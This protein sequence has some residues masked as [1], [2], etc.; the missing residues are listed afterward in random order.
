[1]FGQVIKKIAENFYINYLLN[2]NKQPERLAF[3]FNYFDSNFQYLKLEIF[4]AE[5][6]E[7]VDLWHIPSRKTF[8]WRKCVIDFAIGQLP[9]K[10]NSNIVLRLIRPPVKN[11]EII[12]FSSINIYTGYICNPTCSFIECFEI[13]LNL[14]L[15]LNRPE[16]LFENAAAAE[17]DKFSG[18][19]IGWTNPFKFNSRIVAGILP[20]AQSAYFNFI[21]LPSKIIEKFPGVELNPINIPADF[22]K[23]IKFG[24]AE[25]KKIKLENTDLKKEE[26]TVKPVTKKIIEKVIAGEPKKN[27]I[28]NL[29]TEEKT[30][31]HIIPVKKDEK[32]NEKKI[33]KKE[34]VNIAEGKISELTKINTEPIAEDV[35]EKETK[36]KEVKPEVPEKISE[37]NIAH[38]IEN[39][40][41]KKSVLDFSGIFD[42]N[43]FSADIKQMSNEFVAEIASEAEQILKNQFTALYKTFQFNEKINWHANLSTTEYN[44]VSWPDGNYSELTAKLAA[45]SG[46]IAPAEK[47][48][49]SL[50]AGGDF[51]PNFVFGQNREFV[52]LALAWR[53]TGDARFISKLLELFISF[54][55]QNKTGRGINFASLFAVSARIVNWMAVLSLVSADREWR[56]KFINAGIIIEIE[57]NL[58]FALKMA[59][60]SNDKNHLDKLIALLGISAAGF[61]GCEH[62]FIKNINQAFLEKLKSEFEGQIGPEGCHLSGSFYASYSVGQALLL[63]FDGILKNKKALGQFIS[64]LLID[65]FEEFLRSGLSAV[66]NFLKAAACADGEVPCIGEYYMKFPFPFTLEQNFD[67]V[68][69]FQLASHLLNDGELK[70][71]TGGRKLVWPRLIFGRD[72]LMDYESAAKSKPGAAVSSFLKSGYFSVKSELSPYGLNNSSTHLI[73]DAGSEAESQYAA[74]NSESK[75]VVMP[76]NDVL[77]FTLNHGGTNFICDSGPGIFIENPAMKEYQRSIFSHNSVIL[78]RNSVAK[79]GV[80]NEI[81]NGA[82]ANN[83]STVMP[84]VKEVKY[85]IN[86][87]F[88]YFSAINDM[89]VNYGIEGMV[90]RTLVYSRPYYVLLLDDILSARKKPSYFDIEILFH[91][92]QDVIWQKQEI[93]F[94]KNA[95]ILKSRKSEAKVIMLSSA[96]QKVSVSTARGAQNPMA[97]WRCGN[98]GEI[99]ETTTISS[100]MGFAKAP[101]RIYTLLYLINSDDQVSKIFKTL[102]FNFNKNS[103]T[104]EICHNQFKDFIKL[105]ERLMIDVK[106]IKI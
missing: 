9:F 46:R 56:E 15:K 91:L 70:F 98:F 54:K 39:K 40:K 19:A 43:N 16:V 85:S 53:L 41:E 50:A 55:E 68:P 6:G 21:N 30:E 87:E 88:C 57:S 29:I 60:D 104:I 4:D 10:M 11:N 2:I 80:K 24:P 96:A 83:N 31:K 45:I 84:A 103:Q 72:S 81:K 61:F 106:R 20:D 32:A 92:S 65:E 44:N 51:Y 26:I 34:T 100:A 71:L 25:K 13:M 17:N 14:P 35:N 63:A 105:N 42:T 77:N 64:S 95:M 66:I 89:F 73:F 94:H 97:G 1:M 8:H 23:I 102:K 101:V 38:D 3:E 7:F 48:K 82:S 36:N 59:D 28:S 69:M 78:N 99:S 62:G 12:M 27:E 5:K 75:F 52:T 49:K 86:S 33:E 76:H 74:N 18:A 67:I 79:S 90:R 37:Q 47:G 93:F 22:D 58:K